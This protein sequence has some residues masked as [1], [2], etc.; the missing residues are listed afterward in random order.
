MHRRS[1]A[2]ECARELV[3]ECE[4]GLSFIRPRAS[5]ESSV[6]DSPMELLRN[7]TF[8]RT[9]REVRAEKC[10]KGKK[11]WIHRAKF[12]R[13]AKIIFLLGGGSLSLL[14]ARVLPLSIFPSSSLSP[15]AFST[16]E[17]TASERRA[18][19][20][21]YFI[22]LLP[23]DPADSGLVTVEASSR[24]WVKIWVCVNYSRR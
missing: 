5:R 14:A 9:V 12:H 23:P 8:A 2:R 4:L 10:A 22:L 3:R 18:S 7:F 20:W 24:G 19:P 11:R 6:N 15:A 13:R 16:F 1:L 21:K 17:S